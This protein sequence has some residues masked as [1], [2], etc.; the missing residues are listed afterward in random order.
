MRHVS[1]SGGRVSH[2]DTL[3]YTV[4]TSITSCIVITINIHC[5]HTIHNTML[6]PYAIHIIIVKIKDYIII[7]LLKLPKMPYKRLLL[8]TLVNVWLDGFKSIQ[9]I[10]TRFKPLIKTKSYTIVFLKVFYP[11]IGRIWQKKRLK[12]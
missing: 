4:I 10:L 11:K 5:I 7:L 8:I 3:A 2:T 6:M 12:N 9:A 1:R